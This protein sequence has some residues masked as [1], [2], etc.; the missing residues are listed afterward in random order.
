VEHEIASLWQQGT[1]VLIVVLVPTLLIPAVGLLSG[2]LQG[3]MMASSMRC[4]HLH[5]P[6]LFSFSAHLSRVRLLS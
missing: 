1:K 6:E 3:M 2:L 5:W 4:A